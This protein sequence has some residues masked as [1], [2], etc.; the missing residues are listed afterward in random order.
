M[1]K[2][3]SHT[4]QCCT[5]ESDQRPLENTYS[6][7]EWHDTNAWSKFNYIKS[8]R[9]LYVSTNAFVAYPSRRVH[10]YATIIIYIHRFRFHQQEGLTSN[11]IY[12]SFIEL[13]IYRSRFFHVEAS[14]LF[15]EPRAHDCYLSIDD[16]RNPI[17]EARLTRIEKVGKKD[18]K[19]NVTL[20]KKKK[21]I[22]T[23]FI[24]RHY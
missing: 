21:K 8:L 6:I 1:C 15:I 10:V 17:R 16:K 18:W 24:Q 4:R 13:Y 2:T 5:G 22:Y 3:L 14:R 20:F 7:N 11:Y 23:L 19:I 12:R 9:S